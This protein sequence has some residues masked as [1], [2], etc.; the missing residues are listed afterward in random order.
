MRY[1]GP[2]WASRL[3]R[4]R[5]QLFFFGNWCAAC[6]KA[7]PESVFWQGQTQFSIESTFSGHKE[8]Q[9]VEMLARI[10]I[11][12]RQQCAAWVRNGLKEYLMTDN[13]QIA[14]YN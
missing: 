14:S 1:G 3:C 6:R 12:A 10:L 9:V 4:Q 11:A 2:F 13:R 8:A 5:L 7:C